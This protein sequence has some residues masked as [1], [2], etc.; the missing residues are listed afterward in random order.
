MCAEIYAGGLY[1]ISYDQFVTA[2][3]K[4]ANKLLNGI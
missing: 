4:L 1:D 2:A 3:V